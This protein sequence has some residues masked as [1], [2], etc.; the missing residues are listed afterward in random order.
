[1]GDRGKTLILIQQ[2]TGS[3]NGIFHV[4]SP[5]DSLLLVPAIL[6][7]CCK[8]NIAKITIERSKKTSILLLVDFNSCLFRFKNS[9][10]NA[11]VLQRPCIVYLSLS[12]RLEDRE[13][14][15]VYRL[16]IITIIGVIDCQHSN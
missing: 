12:H 15:G 5:V 7:L 13:V 2:D 6:N 1:M 4:F 14:Q 10:P 11:K 9:T 3:Q 8:R 16:I